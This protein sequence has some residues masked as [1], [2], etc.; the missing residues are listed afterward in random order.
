M[1]K[2]TTPRTAFQPARSSPQTHLYISIYN[3]VPTQLRLWELNR[4]LLLQRLSAS[5][6][7]VLLAIGIGYYDVKVTGLLYALTGY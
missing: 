4:R 3:K 2:T 5:P 1:K 6:L 7:S